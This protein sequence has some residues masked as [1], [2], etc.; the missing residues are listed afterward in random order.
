MAAIIA[1]FH[2]E[3]FDGTGYP[4]GLSGQ[5]IPLPARIV[6]LAD[7]YDAITSA[8]PY[9][10]AYSPAHARDLVQRESGASFRSGSRGGISTSFLPICS[11]LIG[12]SRGKVVS[13]AL[14]RRTDGRQQR[15]VGTIRVAEQRLA[16]LRSRIAHD[17]TDLGPELTVQINKLQE[18]VDDLARL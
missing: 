6:A 5:Q 3:R 4:A 10:P 12:T 8:R 15:A 18:L 17:N 13:C 11:R 1:R 9:K 16:Q 2:H 14:C 7:V